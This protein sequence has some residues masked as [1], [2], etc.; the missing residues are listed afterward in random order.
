MRRLRTGPRFS[1]DSVY[2]AI[3]L[4]QGDYNINFSY[5]VLPVK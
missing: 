3:E 2:W 5:Y 4:Y 1:V